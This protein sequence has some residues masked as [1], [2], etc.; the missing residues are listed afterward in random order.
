MF[1]CEASS[2]LRGESD[3]NIKMLFAVGKGLS[4]QERLLESQ[5]F[6]L[7]V[8]IKVNEGQCC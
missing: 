2:A 8:H 3:R 5:V 4:S 6:D 7:L 1:A